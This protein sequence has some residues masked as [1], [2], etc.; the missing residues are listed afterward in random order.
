MSLAKDSVVC[1]C[2][3]AIRATVEELCKL[4]ENAADHG[5]TLH[6]T[7]RNVFDHVIRMG[8]QAM[9]A[10][11]QLQGNGDLGESCTTEDGRTL[12]R[13]DAPQKRPLRTVFGEHVFEQYVYSAGMHRTIEFR[14][15][16]ARLSASPRIASY[17]LE[18]FSQM[19]CVETAFGQASENIATVFHQRL[20][21]DTLEA[22]SQN[23]G[24]DADQYADKLPEPPSEEEGALLV[25]TMDAKGVPLIQE[26]PAKVK[27][28]ET[29]KLRPGN[30]RMATLAGVYSV[31]PHVRTA[32]EIVAALFRDDIGDRK[33][34]R[35]RPKFK[36]LTVHF[37]E[38][39]DDGHERIVST[40]G[41]EASAWLAAEVDRRRKEIQE[42]VLLIDGDHYLWDMATDYLPADTTGILDIVHVSGYVWEASAVFCGSQAER[43]A[44]TRKRLLTILQGGVKS[45]IRGM[46]RMV[47]AR[48]LT[49]ESRKTISRIANYFEA[50]ATRMR[51]DEYL[52]KGFP[53]ATGVIEGACRHLVKDRMERSGM[54]WTLEGAKAMLNVRAVLASGYWDEFHAERRHR[55]CGE[56][57]RHQYLLGSYKPLTVAL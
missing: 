9:E 30:R 18:E 8:R 19:F 52:K 12:W 17:L 51:Y 14:P 23:M 35:P 43:E 56:R 42:L 50:H 1:K 44:F 45:V 25:A 33:P 57:H 46:R 27:A 54:R 20:S 3:V 48:G 16:D 41:V 5:E 7:E 28:F 47:T 2:F 13:S 38:V 53:I 29:R 37:P 49:G 24:T 36:H 32:K 22:I 11:L 55:E 4:V 15:I 40:G 10:F 34:D 6:E 21:V 31:E 39:Y 26:Q